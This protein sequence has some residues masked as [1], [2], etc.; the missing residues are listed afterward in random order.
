M[1]RSH[2]LSAITARIAA[3]V[4]KGQRPA[5]KDLL[6]LL[7]NSDR[8]TVSALEGLADIATDP[9][10]RAELRCDGLKVRVAVDEWSDFELA[11]RLTIRSV[12]SL[13]VV[14]PS[15]RVRES[16][17][18]RPTDLYGSWV[19][20][21]RQMAL[22]S[23]RFLWKTGRSRQARRIL[24]RLIRLDDPIGIHLA[25][26]ELG[27]MNLAIGNVDAALKHLDDSLKS[28]DADIILK[29]S[30]ELLHALQDAGVETSKLSAARDRLV[31]LRLGR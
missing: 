21:V 5:I 29:H 3:R 8:A 9:W 23:A 20:L 22:L 12:R 1:R 28:I 6:V 7:E 30:W 19:L 2:D 17:V 4:A 18:H 16:L 11:A 15:P 27:L 24:S 26:T 14:P 25:E 13:Q 31:R 10:V